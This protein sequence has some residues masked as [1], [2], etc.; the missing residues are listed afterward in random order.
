[1]NFAVFIRAVSLERKR[2]SVFYG[3]YLGFVVFA[4]V[5]IFFKRREIVLYLRTV[6]GFHHFGESVVGGDFSVARKSVFIVRL[7]ILHNRSHIGIT[8]L[9]GYRVVGERLRLNAVDISLKP[10]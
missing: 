3:G 4:L 2:I 9:N 6:V 8:V 5:E 1:M 10:A 7:H